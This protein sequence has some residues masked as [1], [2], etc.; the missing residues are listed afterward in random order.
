MVVLAGYKDKMKR[1]MAADPGMP[2]RFPQRLHLKDYTPSELARIANLVARDRFNMELAE[3]VEERIAA[4]IEQVHLDEISQHNGGLSVNLVE[5][6]IGRMAAR[7]IAANLSQE[8]GD[9]G[10]AS[11]LTAEDFEIGT[12]IDEMQPDDEV[13]S[14]VEEGDDIR[15]RKIKAQD[16]NEHKITAIVRSNG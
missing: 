1:L 11:I 6:A 14:E 8:T 7:T 9:V 12:H 16:K 4:H 2:R 10:K 5:A 13:Q 3:G 15:E